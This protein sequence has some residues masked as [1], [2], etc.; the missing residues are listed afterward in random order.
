MSLTLFLLFIRQKKM[1]MMTM[2][3][4]HL[5]YKVQLFNKS[6][7]RTSRTL[8]KKRLV[9]LTIQVNSPVH[10]NRRQNFPCSQY[11]ACNDLYDRNCV[12]SPFLYK[13]VVGDTY[14]GE[15]NNGVEIEGVQNGVD[16]NTADSALKDQVRTES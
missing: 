15:E 10:F 13:T 8:P 1:M 2:T 11:H 14:E 6:L 9:L 3:K 12:H 4:L 5:K 7:N 16:L